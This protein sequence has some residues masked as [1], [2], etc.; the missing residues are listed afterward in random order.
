MSYPISS[1]LVIMATED[2]A[3]YQRLLKMMF[4]NKRI[5]IWSQLPC[6]CDP[7]CPQPSDEAMADFNKR[8]NEDLAAL[9]E[10]AA[11]HAKPFVIPDKITFPRFTKEVY[12]KMKTWPDIR[13]ILSAP[14]PE[15]R[16]M[17][18]SLFRG[19][20]PRNDDGET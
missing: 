6:K 3:S 5:G 4:Y 20:L 18:A 2:E 11:K 7:P 19:K 13:E 1:C 15:L 9:F 14:D 10:E 16:E 8:M 12:D 17:M